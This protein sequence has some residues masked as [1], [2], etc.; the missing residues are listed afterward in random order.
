MLVLDGELDVATAGALE[1]QLIQAAADEPALLVLDLSELGFMD[2]TGLRAVL[3]AAERAR[4]A[5][6][7]FAV[8]RGSSQVQRLFELTQVG[9]RL[10]IV[11]RLD[12]L[13]AADSSA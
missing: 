6:Y 9:E 8:V 12:D 3:S 10:R 4:H 1:H 11:D 5:A 2:S 7:E 13:F